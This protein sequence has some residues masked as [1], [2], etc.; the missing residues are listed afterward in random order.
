[1]ALV[2]LRFARSNQLQA[3]ARNSPALNKGARGEG[4]EIL[5]RSLIDLGFAMPI[6]TSQVSKLPDGIYGNE[7]AGAVRNF[8]ARQA[9]QQDAIAGRNTLNRL[10]QLFSAAEARELSELP[11]KANQLHWT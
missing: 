5:Q 4:V 2:S 10:D 1:M 9:L 7:T 6:S 3:A 11:F 8:Q